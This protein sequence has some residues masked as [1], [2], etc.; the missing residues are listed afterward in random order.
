MLGRGTK[1]KA[2][3]EE[4]LKSGLLKKRENNYQHLP[5][6][7]KYHK[8]LRDNLRREN[9]RKLFTFTSRNTLRDILNEFKKAGSIR[10]EKHDLLERSV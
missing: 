2:E 9:G 10:E 1:S 6:T 7:P 4:K 8:Q 3:F 5:E